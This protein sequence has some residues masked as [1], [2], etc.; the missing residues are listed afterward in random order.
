MLLQRFEQ[1]MQAQR[2]AAF[3]LERPKR[4]R[5]VAVLREMPLAKAPVHE[6]ERLE[7]GRRHA[8]IVHE[9]GLAQRLQP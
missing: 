7:L 9:G 4:P 5:A 3:G 8:G 2:L 6:L 1:R